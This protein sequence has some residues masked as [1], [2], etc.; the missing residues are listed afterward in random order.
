MRTL[1]I[2]DI[3][4]CVRA[5]DALLEMVDPSPDDLVVALG[6]YVDRG[7]DSKGVL[8]RMIALQGH[9]KCLALKGNHDLMMLAGRGDA[10]QFSEWLKSGGKETLGSYHADNDWRTFAEAIPERH[11]RFLQDDCVPYHKTGHALFCSRQCPSRSP[12]GGTARLHALLGDVG[13]G[14]VAPPRVGQ[15]DGLRSQRAAFRS[16]ARAR[17]RRL[18]RHLG[19]RRGLADLPG[20][21]V[22]SILASERARPDTHGQLAVSRLLKSPANRLSS[23]LAGL[24]GP[25][26]SGTD[27]QDLRFCAR[28]GIRLPTPLV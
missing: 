18:H 13:G 19:L 25:L 6:D 14:H 2:G 3:H 4:G 7:P 28:N 10:E 11:W 22:G 17:P 23:A 12:A 20:R 1:A 9:C 27:S 5:F 8:D 26:V 16:T 15:D 21:R 24:T